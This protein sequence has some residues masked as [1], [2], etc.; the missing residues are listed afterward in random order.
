MNF[1]LF[2][3]QLQSRSGIL[4]L[5]E[6]LGKALGNSQAMRMMGGGNPARIPELESIWRARMREILD[7]GDEFDRMLGHYDPPTGNPLFLR[8][9]ADLLRQEY[10]WN[11]GPE[12]ISV[13]H[14]GQTAFFCLFNLLAGAFP[15]GSH[16]RI[17]IPLMPEYIGY[18]AQGLAPGMFR[19]YRPEIE[20]IDARTFKYHVDFDRIEVGDDIAAICV[21]RPTNPTANVLTDA[22]VDHL[23]ALAY[24]RNIPLIIDNAYGAPFPG[25]IFSDARP[26][27]DENIVL[28]LSLSKLG[29]PG[30]RTGIVI[31]RSEII[32]AISSFNSVV[33][34]SNSGIGQTIVQPL[35]ATGD[36]LGIS[37]AIIRPFYEEKARR[38]IAHI[39]EA[40]GEDIDYALHRSEGAFFLW[41]WFRSL[42]VTTHALYER[43][44]RRGVL[45]VPGH[46]FFYGL[47]EPWDHADQCLRLTFTQPDDVV[48][49]G[50]AILADE[51]R[52]L[53]S[54]SRPPQA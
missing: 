52:T 35:L 38:A 42:P 32:E 51:V 26:V 6:D 36:L 16:R 12:N 41:I 53:Q 21:S 31:A 10:G 44:K 28:T 20:H 46:Y 7:N 54:E 45:I 25:V 19:S 17:L 39:R 8:T 29:L 47:D 40:F 15:D 49:D 34:L 33:G 18:A 1:S 3:Q 50:I 37:R 13:T 22:E 30:T 23:R 43:L 5:M 9:L 24:R 4:E 2:G 14:G 27:W 11:I 48:R